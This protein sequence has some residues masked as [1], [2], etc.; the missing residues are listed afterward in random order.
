MVTL[1]SNRNATAGSARLTIEDEEVFDEEEEV[2]RAAR[3]LGGN[4]RHALPFLR[5]AVEVGGAAGDHPE[6]GAPGIGAS[7]VEAGGDRPDGRADR[8]PP[9]SAQSA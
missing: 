4:E 5:K 3:L 8:A 6:E 7:P 9:P 2:V 1:N